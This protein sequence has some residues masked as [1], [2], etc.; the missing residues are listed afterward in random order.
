MPR[1]KKRPAFAL[2]QH[3]HIC[4]DFDDD[5]CPKCYWENNQLG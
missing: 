4:A 2:L 1:L 5:F 3:G